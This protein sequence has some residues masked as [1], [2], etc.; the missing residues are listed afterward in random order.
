MDEL[1]YQFGFGNLHS[2]DSTHNTLPLSQNS[3]Q[4][5]PNGLI[6]EQLNGSAFTRDRNVNLHSWLYKTAPSAVFS[7][8]KEAKEQW[9]LQSIVPFSPNQVRSPKPIIKCSNHVISGTLPIAKN[10]SNVI[11]S[12]HYKALNENDFF[13]NS[14]GEL[15]F[16]NFNGTLLFTT[17]FG[18]LRLEPCEILVIPRGVYFSIEVQ[19]TSSSGY[20]CENQGL[21]LQLPELGVIGANGLAHPRHFKYPKA[22]QPL[23]QHEANVYFKQANHWWHTASEITP[24]N[25]VAWHGN[26]APYKYSL[27]DFNTINTVSFDHPDPSIFTVLTSLSP[28]KGV[29]NLDFVIFPAR[30][31]CAEHTFR[32][33]YFHRNI[34]SEFM[35]LLKGQYDAKSD[36]FSVGGYSIHNCMMGHGPDYESYQAGLNKDTSQP[37]R[38]KDTLAFMLESNTAWQLIDNDHNKHNLDSQY[39]NCWSGFL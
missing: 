24:I 20:L 14:D 28:I 26:Y 10:D 3:P 38:Y 7:N 5:L 36:A 8:F 12:Y 33:P 18:K 1:E 27:L 11:Y 39:A 25:T 37:E 13:C 21:P 2:S 6:A 35:G 31:M 15:L 22:C 9:T 32:P 23:P 4:T 19:G 29:A 16:I 17:E 30:W 34:M